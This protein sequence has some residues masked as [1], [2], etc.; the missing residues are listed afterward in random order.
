MTSAASCPGD[1]S[2][3][4]RLP[5]PRD[6][7]TP[8]FRRGNRCQSARDRSAIPSS[9]SSRPYY[10]ANLHPAVP[11]PGNVMRDPG[12]YDA[13]DS[14]HGARLH[15]GKDVVNK[16]IQCP[17]IFR[18]YARLYFYLLKALIRTSCNSSNLYGLFR[19]PDTSPAFI[20]EEDCAS[21]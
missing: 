1:A 5:R 2:S 6:G 18:K 16:Y 12:S 21:P 11:A 8:E 9:R 19:Y 7:W 10:P 20:R 17:C 15:F 4:P 3:P 13:G 14:W